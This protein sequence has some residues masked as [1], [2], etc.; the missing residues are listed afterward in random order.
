MLFEEN[1]PNERLRRARH[2]KGWTQSELADLRIDPTLS[3]KLTQVHALLSGSPA[4]DR[5]PLNACLVNGISTDQRGVKRPDG[6]EQSCD[7]GAY[8]YADGPT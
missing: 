2:L 6:Q 5:I 4:I 3:G 1:V 7:I 8:E